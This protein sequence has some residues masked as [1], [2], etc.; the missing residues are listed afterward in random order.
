MKTEHTS[1]VGRTQSRATD[2]WAL[3][4]TGGGNRGA[5]QAG[6][7]LAL[8][9]SGFRPDL[10]VG[11]SVGAINGSYLAFYPDLSGARKLVEFWRNLRSGE[12][13]GTGAPRL[14]ALVAFTLRRAAAFSNHGFRAILD[15]ELPSR[16]FADTLVPFAVTATH[17]ES[18]TARTLAD[19][20]LI[21]AVLASAAV[22]VH[23]PPVLVAGERLIDGAV[24]DPVPLHIVRERGLTRAV[25]IEPGHAC[26]CPRVYE[27]ALSIVQQSVAVLARRCMEAEMRAGAEQLDVVHIG[28]A[29]YA[30][31]PLTDLSRTPAMLSSGYEEASG[32]LRSLPGGLPWGVESRA[33]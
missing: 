21:E 30:D 6:A 1:P 28:L 8:F 29:C 20:D 9:E 19:G 33:L 13:F 12:L 16:N 3:I 7:L 31:V 10:I 27:S 32:R 26:N 24:A 14:R 11:V 25:I 18:G 5:I 22:P 17:L 2:G 4:L 15:R 23:L